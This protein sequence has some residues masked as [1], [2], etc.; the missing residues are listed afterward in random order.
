MKGL[1]DIWTISE[2]L[3]VKIEC[4]IFCLNTDDIQSKVI[5][6]VFDKKIKRKRWSKID[7]IKLFKDDPKL[8]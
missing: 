4:I 2:E 5:F 7:K 3:E 1:L 6:V 8:W